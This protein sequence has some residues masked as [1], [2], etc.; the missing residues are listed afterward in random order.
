MLRSRLVL[1]LKLLDFPELQSRQ[2]R[3]GFIPNVLAQRVP[4]FLAR[5]GGGNP[6]QGRCIWGLGK[7]GS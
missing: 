4:A 1:V 6:E 3:R 2:E 7:K 5:D